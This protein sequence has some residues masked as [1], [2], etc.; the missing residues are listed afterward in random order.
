MHASHRLH[1]LRADVNHQNHPRVMQVLKYLD[2][3]L[4]EEA[5]STCQPASALLDS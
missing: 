5:R 1:C 2:G 4:P 3:G